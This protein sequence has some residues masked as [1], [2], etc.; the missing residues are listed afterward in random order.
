LQAVSHLPQADLWALR[1]EGW[2]LAKSFDNELSAVEERIVYGVAAEIYA[3]NQ[4]G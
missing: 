3:G 2:M 4:H 1:R